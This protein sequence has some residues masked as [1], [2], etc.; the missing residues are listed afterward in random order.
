VAQGKLAEEL[1]SPLEGRRRK[2]HNGLDPPI[3]CGAQAEDPTTGASLAFAADQSRDTPAVPQVDRVMDLGELIA[4]SRASSPERHSMCKSLSEE[5][6]TSCA[7][8]GRW[9]SASTA[10]AADHPEGCGGSNGPIPDQ[11]EGPM[12]AA[13]GGQW[14]TF[15]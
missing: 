2:Q 5:G 13:R 11:A 4:A 6:K 7:G 8:S 9:M 10:R 15:R 14:V 12:H 3:R 1:T